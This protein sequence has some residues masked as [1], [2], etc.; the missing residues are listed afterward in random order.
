MG[1]RIRKS[2][3]IAP[4]VRLN[5]GKKGISTSIGKRGVGV[6]F[7]P[8]GTTAHISVPGTGISY[9]KKTGI[10]KSKQKEVSVNTVSNSSGTISCLFCLLFLLIL[11]IAIGIQI[12]FGWI[13]L[14]FCVSI[15]VCIMLVLYLKKIMCKAKQILM[16]KKKLCI[17]FLR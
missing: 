5:F 1:L 15:I 11:V 12:K 14:V 4:G 7:G 2:V 10:S 13:P 17:L 16:N 3:K 9:V 6:T 8:T